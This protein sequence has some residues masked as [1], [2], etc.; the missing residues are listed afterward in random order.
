M[1][2]KY[3]IYSLLSKV[4]CYLLGSVPYYAFASCVLVSL[5]LL[6]TKP[7]LL[8][9]SWTPHFIAPKYSMVWSSDPVLTIHAMTVSISQAQRKSYF[10]LEYVIHIHA[11]HFTFW[12]WVFAF[13]TYIFIVFATKC[14]VS[15]TQ[16]FS[17]ISCHTA[18]DL[19]AL[20]DSCTYLLI[21]HWTS[22][23]IPRVY[24][25]ILYM[26]VDYFLSNSRIW[27]LFLFPFYSRSR[28]GLFFDIGY[29]CQSHSTNLDNLN[30][31]H[32]II[33]LRVYT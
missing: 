14:C 9:H 27:T 30:S 29:R 12:N 6:Q 13:L 11:Y 18:E 22:A 7:V 32:V 1:A 16:D 20:L 21:T 5:S 2:I 17:S 23:I 33:A 19:S 28:H 10:M 24:L 4:A 25:C 31:E 8:P 15:S 3:L 26:V